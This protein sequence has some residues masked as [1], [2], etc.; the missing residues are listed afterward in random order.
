MSHPFCQLILHA[1]IS[2]RLCSL[3]LD[4]RF[5]S[6]RLRSILSF[7]NGHIP[8]VYSAALRSSIAVKDV[9]AVL[10]QC[11]TTLYV[12][13]SYHYYYILSCAFLVV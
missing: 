1:K 11:N 8:S 2:H 7:A 6:L 9:P 3:S 4:D 13:E 5:V 12:I 10:H